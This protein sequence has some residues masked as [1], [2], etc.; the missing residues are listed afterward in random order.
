MARDGFG[1]FDTLVSIERAVGTNQADRFIGNDDNNVFRGLDGVDFYDGRGGDD[2]IQYSFSGGTQG[3]VVNLTNRVATDPFGNRETFVGIE[4]ADGTDFVD[5]FTGDNGANFFAGFDGADLFNGLGGVDTVGYFY[6]EGTQGV[7]ADL[8]A[9][10]ITDTYGAVDV[11][12]GIEN[13]IGSRFADRMTGDARGNTF[14]GGLGADT[15]NGGAGFDR[16]SYEGAA[17]GGGARLDGGANWGMAAG[18]VF[19]NIEGL[20]GSDFNDTLIGNASANALTGG[21]GNDRLFGLG[22]DDLLTGGEGVDT[23]DGG[24]GFDTASFGD[25]ASFVGARLDGGVNWGAAAG[26]VFVGIE[27]LVGSSF[28]DVLIGSAGANA[29]EGRAG[30]DNLY[31]LGGADRFV[32]SGPGFGADI[33]RDFQN[34]VDLLDF[35]RHAGVDELSDLAISQSGTSVR[36]GAGGDAVFLVGLVVAD[37]DASDFIFS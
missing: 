1:N 21:D 20:I 22:G 23:L 26:E 25:S 35:S 30:V 5:R 15:L 7:V 36:I 33:V 16:A 32:F 8:A 13:V 4:A 37:V 10:R 27:G 31:G 28:G 11:V 9:G 6:D 18:D 2:L 17:S 34:G 29:L 12:V 14:E 19:A 3:V 24:A